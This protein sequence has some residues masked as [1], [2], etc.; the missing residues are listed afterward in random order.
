MPPISG[1]ICW[2]DGIL[3]RLDTTLGV[4]KSIEKVVQNSA[5]S[6]SDN[7]KYGFNT[8]CIKKEDNFG[9]EEKAGADVTGP[10]EVDACDADVIRGRNKKWTQATYIYDE[11]RNELFAYKLRQ[12]QGWCAHVSDILAQNLTR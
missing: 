9:N 5:V 4:M 6:D 8:E 7:D 1:T 10:S 2:A 11:F 12:Y 3:E